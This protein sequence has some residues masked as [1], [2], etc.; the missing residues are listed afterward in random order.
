MADIGKLCATEMNRQRKSGVRSQRERGEDYA[1]CGRL[2]LGQPWCLGWHWCG[3]I[4]IRG[5]RVWGIID[6]YDE[7]YTDMTGLMT[8]FHR[9]VMDDLRNP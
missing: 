8:K 3:Y 6:L 7:P 9:E 2:L 5:G 1:E 4:E